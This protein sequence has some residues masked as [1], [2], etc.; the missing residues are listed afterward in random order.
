[1]K[2]YVLHYIL[3][4]YAIFIVKLSF[5]KNNHVGERFFVMMMSQVVLT[6]P[7]W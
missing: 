2:K 1:M 3:F 7:Q 6:F 4:T 5:H